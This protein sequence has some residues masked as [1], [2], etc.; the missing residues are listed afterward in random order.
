MMG[1]LFDN[2]LRWFLNGGAHDLTSGMDH[3]P[4]ND[5]PVAVL[6]LLEHGRLIFGCRHDSVLSFVRGFSATVRGLT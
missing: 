2:E 3:R 5:N 1:I 4:V 6:D